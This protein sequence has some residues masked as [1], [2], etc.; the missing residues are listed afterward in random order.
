MSNAY[1]KMLLMSHRKRK[2]SWEY[3]FCRIL[4]ISANSD[5]FRIWS[6]F[7][8]SKTIRL[9]FWNI[10]QS[11]LVVFDVNIRTDLKR[12]DMAAS[13]SLY[14]V[15]KTQVLSPNQLERYGFPTIANLEK[16]RQQVRNRNKTCHKC[17]KEFRVDENGLQI[18]KENCTYHYRS[19]SK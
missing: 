19:P 4:R 17:K 16:G 12:F 2:V 11:S 13:P 1:K 14:D 9:C 8:I 3:T 15:L 6:Y 18:V 7:I 5:Y 10:L